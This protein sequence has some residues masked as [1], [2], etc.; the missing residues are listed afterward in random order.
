[1]ADRSHPASIYE[2]PRGKYSLT[3]YFS[4][5]TLF[6]QGLASEGVRVPERPRYQE[7]LQM[8]EDELHH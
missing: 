2:N 5:P 1:M 8:E 3:Q 4:G 7:T 6:D